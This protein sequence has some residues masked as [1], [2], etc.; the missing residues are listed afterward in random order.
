MSGQSPGTTIFVLA[1]QDDDI[2][3]A[4]LIRR[5]KA[6]GAPLRIVYLTD[7]GGGPVPSSVRDAECRRALATLGV[8]SPE[9][10]F[11]GS[12]T[13]IPD[14]G[15][16]RAL[17]RAYDGLEAVLASVGP[18]GDIYT[19]AWEG[20]H[21]DHDA[22][23][24]VTAAFAH[25]HDRLAHA[26]QVPFYRTA[27]RGPPWF[28]LFAPLP[29]NGRVTAIPLTRQ[30]ALLRA[31]LM[32]WY[33]SQWRVLAG[34]GPALVWHGATATALKAQPLRLDRLYERP[35]PERLFYERGHRTRFDEFAAS[36]RGFLVARGMNGRA[37][38]TGTTGHP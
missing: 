32:R 16:F 30:E 33:P 25:A 36:A 12:A 20:G 15:L 2:A 31:S 9:I 3:F 23:H 21:I 26:W 7:G 22:A 10:L 13:G 27:D 11:V 19:L 35:M 8:A 29:A 4:P 28:S 24:V 37:S 5:V 1:H 14:L 38:E 34:L 18:I 6:S 17:D